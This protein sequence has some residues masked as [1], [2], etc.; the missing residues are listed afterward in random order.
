MSIEII[1]AKNNETEN[2]SSIASNTLNEEL[3]RY[4]QTQTPVL[5]LSSGGSSLALLG[6]VDE[7]SLGANITIAPLDER[8]STNPE[9]NNLAQIEATGFIMKAENKGAKIINTRVKDGETQ[10]ELTSRFNSALLQWINDNPQGK[11]ITTVGIG[12]DGHVS[13]IMPFPENPAFFKEHFDDGKAEHLVIGYDAGDKNQYP[14]RVTT[15]MN[16]LRKI[17]TAIVYVVGESKKEAIKRVFADEGNI[18]ETP[19]RILKEIPG[20]VLLFT[21]QS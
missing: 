21:D 18:A 15:T 20:K 19:A 17:D 4:S 2:L 12:P 5:F 6:G 13:G 1:H 8:Y 3:L 11:I 9:E 10:E 14:K 16:L 7:N